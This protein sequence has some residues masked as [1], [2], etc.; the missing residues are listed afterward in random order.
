MRILAFAHGTSLAF[1]LV[2][3]VVLVIDR[4]FCCLVGHEGCC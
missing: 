2:S 4:Y 1:A 3:G